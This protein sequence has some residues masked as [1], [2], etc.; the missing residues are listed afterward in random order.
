MSPSLVL[1]FYLYIILYQYPTH[2]ENGEEFLMTLRTN[3]NVE[4]MQDF[5]EKYK[6][7]RSVY[8][9]KTRQ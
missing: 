8:R 7:A 6:N 9:S 4:Y 3:T 2:I 5:Q 1:R